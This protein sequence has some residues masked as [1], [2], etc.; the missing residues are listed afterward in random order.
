MAMMLR[1]CTQNSLKR[2]EKID[3]TT[4]DDLNPTQFGYI[5]IYIT[6][7]C[8]IRMFKNT[9]NLQKEDHLCMYNVTVI[10]M[11]LKVHD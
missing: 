2:R 6:V 4:L 1:N 5:Y 9:R 11:N 3:V 10:L 7:K 8:S